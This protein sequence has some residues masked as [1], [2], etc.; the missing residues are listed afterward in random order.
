MEV[1][2][3]ATRSGLRYIPPKSSEYEDQPGDKIGTTSSQSAKRGS[4]ELHTC[5]LS[6]GKVVDATTDDHPES[7]ASGDQPESFTDESA[8][9]DRP[10]TYFYVGLSSQVSIGFLKVLFL[11][12]F[13]SLVCFLLFSFWCWTLLLML[14][15]F[16][17]VLTLMSYFD[18]L[19]K[20]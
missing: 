13:K 10:S 6:T 3:S 19:W 4:D 9:F 12:I 2:A 7:V 17:Y 18:T 16:S 8:E 20:H 11:S 5:I 15:L 1:H 14:L